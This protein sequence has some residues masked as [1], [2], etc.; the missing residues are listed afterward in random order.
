MRRWGNVILCVGIGL[1]AAGCPRG[2]TDYSQARKEETLQDLD[3]AL[4]YYQKAYNSDPKNAAYRIKLDQIRFDAS[5]FHVKQGLK[6]KEKG[7]LQTAIGEFQRAT[8]IDPT[9]EAAAQEMRKTLGMIAEKNRQT[10][11]QASPEADDSAYASAPPELKPLSTTP[12]NLRAS[13]DAKVI[14]STIGKLAGIGVI[15]DQDFTARRIAVDF[16]NVTLDQALAL[17]CIQ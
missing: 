4:Q 2:G 15:F 9:N 10:D 8:T 6:L 14:F 13:D 12:I 5:Q 7:D 1:V 11:A 17:A 16:A 3:T